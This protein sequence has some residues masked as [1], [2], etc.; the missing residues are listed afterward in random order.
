MDKMKFRLLDWTY[1]ILVLSSVILFNILGVE[2]LV[3]PLANTYIFPLFAA[4]AFDKFGLALV[5]FCVFCV[6]S[7]FIPICVF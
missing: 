1:I 7:L 3:T 5:F 2:C 6:E 4:V